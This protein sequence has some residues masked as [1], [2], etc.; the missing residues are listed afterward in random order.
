MNIDK[1][2][3][4]LLNLQEVLNAYEEQ[5][6]QKF[7]ADFFIKPEGVIDNIVT[8]AGIMEMSLQEQIAFL[9]KQF[10]PETAESYW[11][12][13]LYERI[14]V[15]RLPSQVTTFT[16]KITGT[17]GYLGEV[18]SI[19]IRSLLSGYEFSNTKDYEIGADGYA[20]VEFGC[21]VSGAIGVNA[22]ES[23]IIVTAPYEVANISDDEASK[24]AIGRERETDSEFRIRFRRS[25][26]QNAKATCNANIAN[27]LQYVD[28][29]A[30]LKVLDK[31]ID[32]KMEAGTV[33]IIAKHNTTDEVFANA[34]F[35]TVALGPVLIGDTTVTVKNKSGQ[36]VEIC[37]KNAD[38][39]PMDIS[40]TIKVRTGYYANTVMPNVKQ[41]ILNYIQKRVY[42]LESIIYATEFIIP[43]L[44][45][46]GVEAVTG[47]QVK[48][49][50]DT[51][52]S[53]SVSLTEVELPVFAFERIT[54][55]QNSQ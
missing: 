18:N 53:D 10:D 2:G 19:V 26:A 4:T 41:N 44:E 11:Q 23:F 25:K 43:L 54:L 31:K 17:G 21:V 42:G 45:V 1:N 51:N 34:I 15:K 20:D 35:D 16:K 38:E 7:G 48:K 37:W 50:S 47:V 8:S 55:S 30:F 32:S 24:I 46:D 27:L 39:I 12:D 22:G 5:L 9:A 49:N 29:Q 36:N 40:G 13:A 6:Q 3:Y 33:K 14:G 28:N 52:F